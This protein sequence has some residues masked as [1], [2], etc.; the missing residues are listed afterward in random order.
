MCYFTLFRFI[1]T[2]E[3]QM[4]LSY[5]F[6]ISQAEMSNIVKSVFDSIR[7]RM[8]YRIPI[9]TRNDCI[10]IAQ[11]FHNRTD[12]PNVAGCLDGKHVRLRCPKNSGSL[13]YNYKNYFS[14]V[15]FA[16]TD[17]KY[18]FIAFD[19]GSFGREGDAGRDSPI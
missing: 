19:I 3:S 6:R 8:I 10:V 5:S 9:P 7:K 4:S 1:T 15:L 16:L 18:K 12:F 13:Y 17:A 14:I 11:E 2:G